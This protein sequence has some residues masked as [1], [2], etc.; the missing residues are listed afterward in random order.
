MIWLLQILIMNK[1]KYQE[2][3]KL[4]IFLLLTITTITIKAQF[5]ESFAKIGVLDDTWVNANEPDKSH[6]GETYLKCASASG[7][8]LNSMVYLKFDISEMPESDSITLSFLLGFGIQGKGTTPPDSFTIDLYAVNNTGWTEKDL[9][10]NNRP[11]EIKPAL[12]TFK[13]KRGVNVREMSSPQFI[14]YLRETRKTG[15]QYVAFALKGHNNTPEHSIWISNKDWRPASL[16]FYNTPTKDL[17]VN[18]EPETGCYK[19]GS[20][21]VSLTANKESTIYYTTDGNVP[22]TRSAIYQAPFELEK[23]AIINAF[24]VSGKNKSY[25]YQTFYSVNKETPVV[26]TVDINAEKNVLPNFW[27]ITGFSPAEML[28]R[29]DMQ[30]TCDMMGAIPNKGLI[31]VRPHYLLNLVAVEGINTESPKYNWTRID[32][33][34]DV[35]IRNDLK[36]IFEIMGTPSSSLDKFDASF[37]KYYQEQTG[38]HATFFTNYHEGEKLEAWKR[39]VK[40]LALHFMERYGQE[41]VRSWYFETCNEPNLSH[42]WKFSLQ[43]FLNYYDACSEGLRE[44][45]PEIRFGGPGLAGAMGRYLRELVAHC[46]TGTNYFTGEKGVR[47]DFISVHVKNR[48]DNMLDAEKKVVDFIKK[49]HPRFANVPFVNDEADPIVGW[50]VDYW[51]RPTPWYAAFI[52]Q[53]VDYHYRDLIDKMGVNYDIMSNDNAFMG[54]WYKRSQLARFANPEKPDN[55]SMVKKPCFTVFSM[56]SLLG[57]TIINTPTSGLYHDHVG[58]IPTMHAD[59]KIA[60]M[61]YN[62]TQIHVPNKQKDERDSMLI[63]CGNKNIELE[64]KNLPL[65]NYTLV[66]YRIDHENSNP[67]KR[68]LEMGKPGNPSTEQILKMRETHEMARIGEPLEIE[69]KNSSLAKMVNIPASSVVLLMLSP[70]AEAIPDK[71]TGLRM[72]EYTGLNKEN[73]IMIRWDDLNNYTI[74]TF[75]VWFSDDKKSFK[76]VNPSDFI[77]NGYLLTLSST[78]KGYIKVRAIDYWGRKGDFSEILHFE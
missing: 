77:D 68:W 10:W 14:N 33:A 56:L 23:D 78:T 42:F 4:L 32:S 50:G 52:A 39:L 60:V 55:F 34:M 70:K 26:L 41:E 67:Y 72:Y 71:P 73:E 6:R 30:Q 49:D 11:K 65:D 7:D 27:N 16:E 37:D 35:L 61:L 20:F 29:A 64:L 69:I 76:K 58:I 3:M 12:V 36:P 17:R 44:A 75:E 63:N 31:Y 1:S 43:E 47:I 53:S 57:K 46:D 21:F 9:T 22:T 54:D 15:V 74:K 40:D 48:P 51:W 25:Y 28:L 19:Q 59:G 45:D 5:L 66:Q 2:I 38:G 13:M 24:A 62:K 18:I 8:S